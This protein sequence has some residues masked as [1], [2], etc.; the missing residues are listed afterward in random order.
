MSAQNSTGEN[1]PDG[2]ARVSG[3]ELVPASPEVMTAPLSKSYGVC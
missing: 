2:N 3:E 1:L